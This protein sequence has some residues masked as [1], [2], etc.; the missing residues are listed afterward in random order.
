[1]NSSLIKLALLGVDAQSSR[2]SR[3]QFEPFA[4]VFENAEIPVAKKTALAIGIEA[5]IDQAS[6]CKTAENGESLFAAKGDDRRDYLPLKVAD[7]ALTVLEYCLSVSDLFLAN[8]CARCFNL[9]DRFLETLARFGQRIPPERAATFINL[10]EPENRRRVDPALIAAVAPPNVRELVKSETSL[11]D[12]IWKIPLF[13]EPDDVPLGVSIDEIERLF[14]DETTKTTTKA[15]ALEALRVIASDRARAMLETFV[16]NVP[17]N[18][19][20]KYAQKLIPCLSTRL[21]PDDAPLLKT[22]LKKARNAVVCIAVA[23]MLAE[24][25]DPDYLQSICRRAEKI[26]RKDWTFSPPDASKKSSLFSLGLYFGRLAADPYAALIQ[27]LLKRI[28]LEHWE[29]YFAESPSV[30]LDKTTEFEQFPLILA[31]FR[32][33]FLFHNGPRRWEEPLNRLRSDKQSNEDETKWHVDALLQADYKDVNAI[34]D[35]VDRLRTHKSA[36]TSDNLFVDALFR[37][38]YRGEDSSLDARFVADKIATTSDGLLVATTLSIFEPYPWRDEFVEFYDS[39]LTDALNRFGQ[40][41]AAPAPSSPLAGVSYYSSQKPCL[42]KSLFERLRESDLRPTDYIDYK[43]DGYDKRRWNSKSEFARALWTSTLLVLHLAP[44]RLR[45]KYAETGKVFFE[46]CVR[47]SRPYSSPR[48]YNDFDKLNE[49][50]PL[51]A[52]SRL[53]ESSR[54]LAAAEVMEEHFFTLTRPE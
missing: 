43:M 10:F 36:S 2:F 50:F 20:G 14:L 33:S 5:L 30:I 52:F 51:F 54:F 8:R 7:A 24:L 15:S 32:A 40:D 22:I 6:P 44:K 12:A 1:M 38:D 28:P 3:S 4:D 11:Y 23:D 17:R 37:D 25:R 19:W 29:E 27:E 35:A 42:H 9:A 48:C 26:L 41:V 21:A 31:G 34:R 13:L 46:R 53:Y 47:P 49:E 16:E 39:T 18:G 45:L